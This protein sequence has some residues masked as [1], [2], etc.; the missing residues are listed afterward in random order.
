M[1]L[2]A[3]EIRR[4]PIRRLRRAVEAGEVTC[5]AVCR[6]FLD[7]IAERDGAVRAWAHVDA[8]AALAEARDRDESDRRG[9]LRG[10]PV[11]VKDSVDTTDM[12]T[13]HGS[14]I[15][16]GH[17]PRA[18]A[19]CVA[20]LREAGAVIL[21]KTAMTEFAGPSPG[22][23]RNPH[24]LARTPGGSSSGSAAAV[25]DGM[26]PAALASQTMG[27][28]IRPAAYCGVV[29]FKPS[30]GLLSMV[31]VK[32]QAPSFDTLGV[33]ARTLD[34]AVAVTEAMLTLPAGAWE[35]SREAP[36][37]IDILRGPDMTLAEA[38]AADALDR[39][40]RVFADAGAEV[41]EVALPPQLRAAYDAQIRLLAYEM[42]RSMAWEWRAHPQT[43]SPVL[44]DYIALGRSISLD[45][46]LAGQDVAAAARAAAAESLCGVDAWLT[47]SAPG[48][49]PH[50][51]AHTGDTAFNRLWTLLHLPAVTL[52]A[53]RGPHGM[54]LGVQLVGAFREDARLVATA[55]WAEGVLA[56]AGAPLSPLAPVRLAPMPTSSSTR[57]PGPDA[58][59]LH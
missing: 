53:G 29:G 54:P 41:S 46:H 26:V 59:I 48:E 10:I 55:R 23:A 14:A 37:R 9:G 11:G 38:A 1:T 45:E 58:R 20:L 56:S 36:P 6:A 32:P 51:L 19:A 5:E 12:P 25:A 47:L 43:L 21:G 52:P 13:S 2:G 30:F 35:A 18:D 57:H 50:G 7:R 16:A 31:G 40:A 42:A 4:A 17:R 28:L 24:D 22:L 49:A 3:Q 15:Y 33:I 39:A 27:S 34:D 8:E 44:S